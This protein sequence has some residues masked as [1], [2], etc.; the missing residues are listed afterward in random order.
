[1]KDLF[2]ANPGSRVELF[3][4]IAAVTTLRRIVVNLLPQQ[5]SAEV[6]PVGVGVLHMQ[7]PHLIHCL[8]RHSQ[9]FV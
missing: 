6:N 1:M 4:L 8:T 5:V 2:V 9:G 7:V 3:V